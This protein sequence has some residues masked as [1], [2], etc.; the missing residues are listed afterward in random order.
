M[1]VLKLERIVCMIRRTNSRMVQGLKIAWE[2]SANGRK[3]A[4]V[5]VEQ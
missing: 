5:R 3:F 2:N 1:S 4:Y